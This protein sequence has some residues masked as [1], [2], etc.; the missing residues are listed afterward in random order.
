MSV[1]RVTEDRR[2]YIRFQHGRAYFMEG[3]LWGFYQAYWVARIY[4][5]FEQFLFSVITGLRASQLPHQLVALLRVYQRTSAPF[6]RRRPEL[7]RLFA[8][9]TLEIPTYVFPTLGVL[10]LFDVIFN[11]S[12]RPV[13]SPN[14]R[15][16]LK[17]PTPECPRVPNPKNSPECP[18]SA[19]PQRVRRVSAQIPCLVGGDS[20]SKRISQLAC[21]WI[22]FVCVWVLFVVCALFAFLRLGM[23]AGPRLQESCN[24]MRFVFMCVCVCAFFFCALD[25]N[26]ANKAQ[27]QIAQ[28]FQTLSPGTKNA[29][30]VV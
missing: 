25:A 15:V 8:S 6:S 4:R 5:V 9:H 23:E 10:G 13:Y 26:H 18:W 27:A 3:L 12:P 16:F 30:Q 7:M 14:P 11:S 1:C 17:C 21:V 24:T 29:I 2:A 20:R 28:K 22:V 19:Q